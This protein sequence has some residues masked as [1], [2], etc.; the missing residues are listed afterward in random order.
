MLG[1]ATQL[2]K[3]VEALSVMDAQV[4][5]QVASAIDTLEARRYAGQ[6]GEVVIVHLGNNG[7]FTAEQFDE[8]MQVL[9]DAR[10]VVFV[11]VKVPRAWEATNNEVL[12]DGVSRYDKA[13]LVDWHAASVDHPEYFAED[14]IHLQPAGQRVYSGLISSEIQTD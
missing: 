7:T 13:E 8:M 2:D 11:N 4:G 14:G 3:E 12:A 5:M 1:A 9:S 6:T 10:K